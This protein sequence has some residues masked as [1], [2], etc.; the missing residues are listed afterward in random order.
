MHLDG[1]AVF[2]QKPEVIFDTRTGYLETGVLLFQDRLLWQGGF[3]ERHD[4]WEKELAHTELRSTIK[5]SKICIE[6]YAEEGDSGLVVVDKSKLDALVGLL[7][8]GW[9][10]TYIVRE[11]FT[12]RQ[13]HGDKESWWFGFELVE[14]PY[15]FEKHYGSILGHRK[16]DEN[17]VC[18]FTIAH[19]DHRRNFS[20]A[21]AA[22]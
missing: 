19:L 12:Y 15:S 1:D 18:S 7:H 21:M 9:Q 17:R 2:L 10:N 3:K 13:G 11:A 14:T 22:C 6:K 5:H 20:A 16:N 4:W 8:I